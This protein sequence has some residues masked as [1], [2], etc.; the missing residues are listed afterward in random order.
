MP[1]IEHETYVPLTAD[2]RLYETCRECGNGHRQNNHVRR[3]NMYGGGQRVLCTR[4]FTS[5]YS[6]CPVDNRAA[7]N[8]SMMEGEDGQQYCN[9][10]RQTCAECGE[11]GIY[12]DGVCNHCGWTCT[13]C[14]G[15]FSSE[16]SSYTRDDYDEYDDEDDGLYCYNCY[17]QQSSSNRGIRGYGHTHPSRWFGG[18]LPR[19]P[20]TNRRLG[21]YLGF[22]LEIGTSNFNADPIHRWARQHGMEDFFDCKEDSSVSGFEIATQPFTPAYFERMVNDGR[23]ASFFRLLN[24]RYPVE[25]GR[26]GSRGNNEEPDGHGLHVHIGRV[27]FAGDDVSLAAYSYLLGQDNS[28][29]LERIARRG[30]TGYCE[31]VTKPVS[32]ALAATQN[33]RPQGNRAYRAGY[34]PNR[35]AI[36]LTNANTVEIRA[37]R[38]TRRPE[39]LAA[40]VRLTYVGAEY[41]RFLRSESKT[42]GID[43]KRLKWT[44]FVRW[45]GV[46]HPQA[47]AA[48]A[49]LDEVPIETVGTATLEGEEFS[50]EDFMPE[51]PVAQRRT[52]IVSQQII[53][54]HGCHDPNCCPDN[55]RTV[56]RSGLSAVLPPLPE[57]PL[58]SAHAYMSDPF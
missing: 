1:V 25:N 43:P 41:I 35:S 29:H 20:E 56:E 22:E 57:R 49:G 53:D 27:L 24:D 46:H 7:D 15:V 36:N 9:Y 11:R 6:V 18:P 38:S 3:Y 12:N 19:D 30:P 16:T 47:F 33:S 51:V 2:E 21:Y 42:K 58:V 37:F 17:V 52:V 31:R 28:K 44:E 26:R 54:S 4:C 39:E 50:I 55:F 34:Y 48:L 5:S 32:V 23:L 8:Y 10:H 14:R 45:A 13:Y 40:A